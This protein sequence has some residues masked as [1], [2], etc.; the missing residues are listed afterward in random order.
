MVKGITKIF[1]NNMMIVAEKKNI[2][3]DGMKKLEG[4]E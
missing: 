1:E 3:R 2:N 4:V